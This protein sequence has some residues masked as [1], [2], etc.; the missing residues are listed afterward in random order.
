MVGV[1]LWIVHVQSRQAAYLHK[2]AVMQQ[3]SMDTCIHAAPGIERLCH[4]CFL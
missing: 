2:V 1:A 3:L 4:A